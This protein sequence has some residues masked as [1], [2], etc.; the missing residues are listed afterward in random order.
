MY[1]VVCIKNYI[2]EECNAL[3]LTDSVACS[4]ALCTS[5]CKFFCFF[6]FLF[7]IN[8]TQAKQNKR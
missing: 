6:L 5:I 4:T 3:W 1:D 8:L 7:F 2:L